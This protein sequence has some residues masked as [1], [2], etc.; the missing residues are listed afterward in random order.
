METR[1][2]LK[3]MKTLGSLAGSPAGTLAAVEVVPHQIA[4]NEQDSP[5]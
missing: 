5:A 4:N 1:T 3:D 2:A